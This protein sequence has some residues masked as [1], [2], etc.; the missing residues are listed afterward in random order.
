M[1]ICTSGPGERSA[2]LVPVPEADSIVGEWRRKCD[3]VAR[4]GVPP[5][6]TLICPWIPPAQITA[7]KVRELS[8][9]LQGTKAFDFHLSHVGWFSGRVVWLAP[10][11]VEP[12]LELTAHLATC[13]GTPPWDDAYDEV[14]PHLTVAHATDGVDLTEVADEVQEFLPIICRADE[15]RV[16]V[17]DG[18]EWKVRAELLL[19]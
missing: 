10:D 18:Q 19:D 9:C 15:V 7:E 4:A 13:F 1:T 8:S 16:M 2:I 11:P 17:G 12:F 5:H 6:V 3:P 14:V